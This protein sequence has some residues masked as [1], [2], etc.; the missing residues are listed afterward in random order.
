MEIS[1]HS[2]CPT[3]LAGDPAAPGDSDPDLAVRYLAR[4]VSEIKRRAPEVLVGLLRCIRM[5]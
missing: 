2:G 1:T 5:C 4:N 3:P